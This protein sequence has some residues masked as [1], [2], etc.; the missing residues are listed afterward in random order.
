MPRTVK[1][2]PRNNE[3][4]SRLAIVSRFWEREHLFDSESRYRR[5]PADAPVVTPFQRFLT[6][7]IYNPVV[8]FHGEWVRDGGFDRNDLIAAVKSGLEHDDDI[9]QQ[10]FDAA[11]ILKLLNAANGWDEIL[12]AVEAISGG[13]ET[14]EKVAAYVKRILPD[15]E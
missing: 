1:E 3:S 2:M 4:A 5:L 11:D 13:R 14:T 15:V 12:L 10:W 8:P 7:T 9:I 6:W